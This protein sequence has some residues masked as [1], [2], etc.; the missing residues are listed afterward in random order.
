MRGSRS[1]WVG[2]L[3]LVLV[4]VPFLI[5]AA[6]P[7]EAVSVVDL[8][9][10]A[11]VGEEPSPQP[12]FQSQSAILGLPLS[13]EANL[14]QAETDVRFLAR[15]G[16]H[17]LLLT[18]SAL[19]LLMRDAGERQ[20]G[21]FGA[22]GR[23][24]RARMSLSFI[25]AD[26][27]AEIQS[28]DPLPGRINYLV[29]PNPDA[30]VT[31]VPTYASV[32][33]HELY[34][35]VNLVLRG[36]RQRVDYEFHIADGVAPERIAIAVE[37]AES[38]DA[39]SVGGLVLRLAGN[40]VRI[41]QPIVLQERDGI[42]E[43]IA[44]DYWLGDARFGF[45]VDSY[46]PEA[47]LVIRGSMAI[48]AEEAGGSWE[49]LD[50][51]VSVDVGADGSIYVA[52]RI[53]VDPGE[54]PA[55]RGRAPERGRGDRSRGRELD[56]PQTIAFAKDLTELGDAF[57][58]KLSPD[59]TTLLHTTYFG[60]AGEDRP[61]GIAVDAEGHALITGRTT[62]TGFPTVSAIQD[63]LEGDSDA[64]VL[65]LSPEGEDLVF[66]T[67]LG[68]GGE[69][70]GRG[71][72]VDAGG[73]IWLVG[74]SESSNLPVTEAASQLGTGGGADAFI[75]AFAPDGSE[76]FH[77]S[78]LGGSAD[79]TA[80]AV[81]LDL[82]G[83]AYIAGRTESADFPLL[84]P[85]QREY[86]GAG[87]A[88]V[89]KIAFDGSGLVYS[90]YVGGRETDAALGIVVDDDG[91]VYLTG[92]TASPAFPL[93]DA[94]Q[95][96]HGG[97]IAGESDAFVVKIDPD[98]A[99]LVYSTYLGG[100]GDDRGCDI[101]LDA[102]GNA[103]VTGVTRSLDFPT[104]SPRHPDLRGATDA[105]VT[106]L[107]PDGRRFVTS[108]FLGGEADDAASDIALL[109]GGDVI[110]AGATRSEDLIE[111]R[112]LEPASVGGDVYV[113]RLDA[114]ALSPAA[115]GCPG[116]V[117]FDNSDGTF[118][119]QTANNWD[120]NTLPTA[121]DDVCIDGFDVVLSTGS[122]AAATLQVEAGGSLTISAGTLT[123]TTEAVFAGPFTQS[124]GVLTGSA[125]VT[126]A[127]L[128]TWNAGTQGG[129][130]TTTANGG[131][132]F[133]TNTNKNVSRPVVNPATQTVTWLD[134]GININVNGA[135]STIRVR[136]WRSTRMPTSSPATPTGYSST[137]A[138]SP[139]RRPAWACSGPRRST[140]TR[141]AGR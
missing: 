14:G 77:S 130:G 99:F 116:S 132:L 49:E 28:I 121:G 106:K 11:P 105:F 3:A 110:V 34:P 93:V 15:G 5:I 96:A 72:A 67:L 62:S 6:D 64:F 18:P 141:T 82:E 10:A 16:G 95:P 127:G 20:A 39:N 87:D 125:N 79:D 47:S 55:T 9:P 31:E 24:N 101:A 58:A 19:T 75:A 74:R 83:N 128:F 112:M 86:G 138:R 44:G 43:R 133:D 117:N 85:L 73:R 63:T 98:G 139:S 97:A 78:Y 45:A 51:A 38:I 22:A 12:A 52:G 61:L 129:T 37:G 23:S 42:V 103:L 81:A 104:A 91:N 107:A 70:E 69:D 36:D 4:T 56:T 108:T 102:D 100:A 66:S 68:G 17:R 90:T 7:G 123:I 2:G 53:L 135:F 115:I 111:A 32:I 119:W 120:T 35:G 59:G 89:A 137:R 84:D 92:S 46:D 140:T 48:E 80:Y 41:S 94:V 30:W 8:P 33:Y 50:G 40:A 134:G 88:F 71:I 26:P 122:Q 27:L 114:S 29:G 25:D 118:L 60:D 76:L 109:P 65:K 131:I 21:P 54:G 1:L 13:F 126:V 57:V 113:A 124:G 136:S